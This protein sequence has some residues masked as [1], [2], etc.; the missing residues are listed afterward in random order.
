MKDLT[1]FECGGEVCYRY[2]T[3]KPIYLL[4]TP[5]NG[6]CS[7]WEDSKLLLADEV[8]LEQLPESKAH[9]LGGEDENT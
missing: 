9:D 8:D 2:G 3:M 7:C 5:R 1:C 4:K 6:L